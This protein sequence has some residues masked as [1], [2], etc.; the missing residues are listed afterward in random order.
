NTKTG[1]VFTSLFVSLVAIGG[2]HWF[3]A[4]ESGA[5][6]RQLRALSER[7]DLASS[8]ILDL[9]KYRRS[10]ASFRKL[11]DGESTAAKER[12]R[13]E[14]TRKAERLNS[15][16]P[17]ADDRVAMSQALDQLSE[18]LL[19]SARIEPTLYTRD[20]YQKPEARE[21]HE[22]VLAALERVGA[23]ARAR[24]EAVVSSWDRF[25]GRSRLWI[26]ASVVVILLT[27][28]SLWAGNYFSWAR[29]SRRL[30]DLAAGLRRG[31]TE[32]GDVTHAH[33]PALSGIHG[34]VE[35]VLR[36]LAATVHGQRLDRHRFI[37]AVAGELRPPLVALQA[38]LSFLEASEREVGS[39]AEREVA[40]DTVKR[41]IQKLSR[42]LDDL[43]DLVDTEQSH[44]R[45]DEKIVDLRSILQNTVRAASSPGM[46]VHVAVP[47]LPIWTH[48]DPQRFERVL[49]QLISKAMNYCSQGG[50]LEVSVERRA[51]QAFRGLEILIQEA[52]R[53][54]A[55]L[56]TGPAQDLLRHWV[57]ESGFGMGLA[58]KIVQAHGGSILASGVAGTGVLFTVRLPAERVAT[59]TVR[60]M[61][62]SAAIEALA[63][64]N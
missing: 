20:F 39:Q 11:G 13:T 54:G 62:P 31:A 46:P 41:A 42:A 25:A 27:T 17:S 3:Q 10:S 30:R 18:F 16:A 12:L 52:A 38:G 21:M 45:L 19:L 14:F 24:E 53:G 15:L 26:L 1:L 61:K 63:F 34:E 5:K 40:V 48:L 64:G 33:G 56:A 57:S 58:Q 49:V 9:E 2:I 43:S 4:R 55:K 35:E 6:L 8:L 37:T 36:Q 23:Q 60:A 22:A 59:G 50:N 32:L 28:V 29:P 7:G 44:L 47:P 51:T